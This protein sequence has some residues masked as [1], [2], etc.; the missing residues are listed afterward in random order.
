MVLAPEHCR[1][2]GVAGLFSFLIC[3]QVCLFWN[4]LRVAAVNMSLSVSTCFLSFGQSLSWSVHGF[5]PLITLSG[6]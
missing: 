5:T 6:T 4:S 1:C 3:C 2:V